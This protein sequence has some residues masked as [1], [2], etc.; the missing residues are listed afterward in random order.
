MTD[1]ATTSIVASLDRGNKGERLPSFIHKFGPFY[2]LAEFLTTVRFVVQGGSMEPN[3]ADDQYLLVSRM[4]L[5]SG[6]MSRG[7]VAVLRNPS[8]WR[9]TYIKRIVGLPGERVG[10]VAERVFIN[11]VLLEEPYLGEPL[12]EADLERLEQQISQG[13]IQEWSLGADEYFVMGDHRVDSDDSRSF[14]PVNRQLIVGKAWIRYWP[15][16]AWGIVK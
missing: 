12:E 6:A 7:D 10:T 8:H 5:W 13:Q 9:R 16:S 15:Q 11:G 4:A 2:K 1:Q 14:G 3:F